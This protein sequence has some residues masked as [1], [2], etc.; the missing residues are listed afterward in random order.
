MNIIEDQL[1]YPYY[2]LSISNESMTE[3]YYINGLFS[4]NMLQ[5]IINRINFNMCMNSIFDSS[6]KKTNE[7]FEKILDYKSKRFVDMYESYKLFSCLSTFKTKITCVGVNCTDTYAANINVLLSDCV[8]LEK[9]FTDTFQDFLS[10]IF[11]NSIDYKSIYTEVLGNE[12]L[13]DNYE[14]KGNF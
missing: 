5:N 14:I 11:H 13:F 4:K 6:T 7:E 1:N 2:L 9:Y 10:N 3:V 12:N 8:T